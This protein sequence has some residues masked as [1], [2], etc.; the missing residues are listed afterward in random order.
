MR[1]FSYA[2]ARGV[3]AAMIVVVL[4]GSAF[5]ASSDE[6]SRPLPKEKDHPFA[7]IVRVIK[8]TIR[9]LGDAPVSPRP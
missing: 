4:A 5:A 9:G 7:K 3:F 2:V 8:K 6:W 1:R